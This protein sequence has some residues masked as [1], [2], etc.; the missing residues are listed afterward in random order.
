MTTIMVLVFLL[1][2]FLLIK[3]DVGGFSSKVL[4]P[5]I[6]DIPYVCKILPK[7]CQKEPI[8]ETKKKEK[9][10]EE[11]K[12]KKTTT[13]EV[14]TQQVTAEQNHKTNTKKNVEEDEE[15]VDNSADNGSNSAESE[16]VSNLDPT[17]Q[18]YVEIYSNMKAESAAAILEGM[19][20]D[21]PLVAE[22]L[23]N[24]DAETRANILAAMSTNN[25]AKIM[26]Y[27][28]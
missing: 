25:A 3:W 8:I 20:G 23:M 12:K 16:E 4:S 18:N 11:P 9:D 28:E 24:M 17:M 15:N 27:M 26:K 2:L 10:E 19:A 21:Y 1:V 7:E 14:T 5:I 13:Q 22:I 6:G